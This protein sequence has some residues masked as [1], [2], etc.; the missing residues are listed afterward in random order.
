MY[1]KLLRFFLFISIT[2]ADGSDFEPHKAYTTEEQ[3]KLRLSKY[4]GHDVLFLERRLYFW[5]AD[6]QNLKKITFLNFLEKMLFLFQEGF[7]I[8]RMRFV[9][10][11]L[12]WD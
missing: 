7:T 4:F 3:I 2:K 5:L 6:N 10:F 9:F 11:L 12:D 1:K 8:E